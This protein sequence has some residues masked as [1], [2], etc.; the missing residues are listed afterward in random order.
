MRPGPYLAAIAGAVLLM[1]C[2]GPAPELSDQGREAPC[3]TV[4]DCRAGLVCYEQRCRR[5]CDDDFI[6]GLG[7]RCEPPVCVR[8]YD[9]G[10][11]SGD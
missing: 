11:P 9:G 6:C 3:A 8:L 1:A 5:A 2:G 10:P 4:A 7:Y